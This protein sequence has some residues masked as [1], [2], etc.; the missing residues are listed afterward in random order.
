MITKNILV[1]SILG[2]IVL[3]LWGAFSHMVLPLGEVGLQAMPNE[4][5]V[6]SALSTN[7]QGAGLYFFPWGSDETEADMKAWEEKYRSGPAGLLVYRPLG[8]E[9]MT[10]GMLLTELVTDIIAALLGSLLMMKAISGLA[11]FGARVFFCTLL[12]LFGSL[13]VNTQYWNWYGFP[14]DY[15]LA[16]I[17]DDVIGFT[18][19]GIVLSWKLIA[20]TQET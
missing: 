19:V 9:P 11:T 15:T 8:G 16:A 5:Q 7:V 6:L 3:F 14:G 20:S 17:L 12:G 18:L 4:E 2:G 1:A 13:L 10:P